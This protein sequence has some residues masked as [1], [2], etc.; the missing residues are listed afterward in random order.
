MLCDKIWRYIGVVYLKRNINDNMLVVTNWLVNHF[1]VG[2]GDDSKVYLGHFCL[3]KNRESDLCDCCNGILNVLISLYGRDIELSSKELEIKK[4]IGKYDID[5]NSFF[6]SLYIMCGLL[7]KGK[8]HDD[9]LVKYGDIVDKMSL[10]GID[11]DGYLENYCHVFSD[12]MKKNRKCLKENG[13]YSL[14]YML[15]KSCFDDG[16]FDY[17]IVG[18]YKYFAFSNSFDSLECVKDIYYNSSFIYGD[19]VKCKKK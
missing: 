13:Y 5:D 10:L 12:V 4:S 1:I 3:N 14:D 2:F 8:S 19:C 15:L 17:H 9:V 11:C 18:E 16:I 7:F 6:D